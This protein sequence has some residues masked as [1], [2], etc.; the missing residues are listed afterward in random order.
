MRYQDKSRAELL[1]ELEIMVQQLEETKDYQERF[2]VLS[3]Y[4]GDYAYAHKIHADGRI[5]HEWTT[6][7]FERITG[8]P[9]GGKFQIYHPDDLSRAKADVQEVLK[10]QATSNEYRIVKPD[11]AV[12]SLL[13]HRL[14]VWDESEGRV[15]RYYG[16]AQD[17]TKRREAEAI[18]QRSEARF[19]SIVDDQ[20]DFIVRWTPDFKLTFVNNAYA[21]YREKSPD[22]LIGSSFLAGIFDTE[23]EQILRGIATLSPENPTVTSINHSM[24]FNGKLSYQE[25]VNRAIF[26]SESQVLEYQSVG[27][28]ITHRIQAEEQRLELALQREKVRLLEELVSDLSHDIKTPIANINTYFYLLRKQTDPTKQKQYIDVLDVQIKRLNKL[29]DDIL[30]VSQLDKGQT[31]SLEPSNLKQ[32]L[33]ELIAAYQPSAKYKKIQLTWS[34]D[35]N[36]PNIFAE[37]TALSRAIANLIENAINY[38]PQNGEVHLKA[39]VENSYVLVSIQDNGIGIAEEDLL[40]IFERFYRA[41]KSRAS[42]TGGTG[43]GLAIVKKVIEQHH[44]TISVQSEPNKGSLFTIRL[45]QI[46]AVS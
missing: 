25:W 36:L 35:N 30:T 3:E 38:T 33:E 10:G 5:M 46:E 8:Y 17:V 28:D 11:G 19:R 16:I 14:P 32:I 41:D 22:E 23:R 12:V 43:L 26:N 2:R 27:R 6:G 24:A 40:H 21:A 34:V 45:P 4:M 39:Y 9:P 1:A 44:G 42:N 37:H 18:M 29:V 15:V 31:L 13:I 7:S 20:T